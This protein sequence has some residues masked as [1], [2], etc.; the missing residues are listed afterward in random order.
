LAKTHRRPGLVGAAYRTA[1]FI[2]ATAFD[3]H[4]FTIERFGQDSDWPTADAT[5]FYIFLAVDRTIDQ[6]F[7]LFP[8]VRTPN[9]FSFQILHDF[10]QS[11]LLM[12]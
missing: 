9:G 6:D 5:V 4:H 7:D 3:I 1:S 8:A 10:I 11:S 2:F 12:S